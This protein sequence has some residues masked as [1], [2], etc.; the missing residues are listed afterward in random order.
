MSLVAYAIRQTLWRALLN[1]T[2]AE[3]RV[4][5][6][7]VEPIDDFLAEKPQPFITISTDSESAE[8][9]GHDYINAD[10]KMDV[11]IVVGLATAIRDPAGIEIPHTDEGLEQALN[12]MGRQVM[13]VLQGDN[14]QPWAD[15]YRRLSIV[16]EKYEVGRGA[17]VKNGVRFAARQYVITVNPMSEPNFGEPASGVW[18]DLLDAMRADSILSAFAD[19]L[20]AEIIGTSIP[21][22]GRIQSRQGLT[23]EGELAVGVGPLI[24]G[25]APVAASELD[26]EGEDRINFT[27]VP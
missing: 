11:V 23:L 10:R 20:E 4:F 17:D 16:A 22:W 8:I 3:D 9:S 26:G 25:E 2:L 19:G 24:P 12:Y 5:D 15:L 21:N 14:G 1:N 7:A 13:R 6:S 27:E 18:A